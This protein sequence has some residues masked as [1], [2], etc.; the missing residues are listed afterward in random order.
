[1]TINAN[2]KKLYIANFLTGII[3]WYPIEKLFMQDI[4]ISAF[5]VGV[6]AVV[7]LAI[8]VIFDVPSGVLADR[9]NRKRT[10]ILSLVALALSSLVLGLSNSLAPYLV[11]TMLF[12]AYVVLTS[13]TYQAIMYDSLYQIGESKRYD[14]HQGR[15]YAL[16]LAGV[17]FSSLAGGYIADGFG[18]RWSYYLSII[19]TF[20]ALFALLTL[21]EPII[22]RTAHDTRLKKHI[23]NSADLLFSNKILFHLALFAVIAGMLRST[24]NEFAGLY[25]IALGL[26]AIPTGYA[27]AA[28]WLSGTAGQFIAEKIGRKVLHFIPML[29]FTFFVFTLIESLWGLIFFYMAVFLHAVMQNQAE[30]EIQDH[31]PSEIRA[32]TLSLLGFATNVILIPIGLLFGWITQQVSVYAAYQVLAVVGLI[33]SIVWLLR[34]RAHINAAAR[35]NGDKEHSS[36]NPIEAE[37]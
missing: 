27:N 14:K 32:T 33:Y 34:G 1:M 2:I 21:V 24:Q 11:G 10:L 3:F 15:A 19:P 6:N 22:I 9:W 35:N 5:G 7:F 30:A 36:V 8:T 29:F 31:T 18:Y 16:F 37:L 25:Y 4:G 26:T 17:G 23:K 13:G 12:G 20:L 28:R